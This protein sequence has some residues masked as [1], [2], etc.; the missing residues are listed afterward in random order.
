MKPDMKARLSLLHKT[1]AEWNA[2]TGFIPFAGEVIIFDPDRAHDYARLKLG[3]GKTLLKDLPFFI[4][5]SINMY[6]AA[7]RLSEVID[8]GRI[9]DYKN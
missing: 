5:S 9:S 3:D 8:G 4:D 7:N 2:L 6:M 1:E